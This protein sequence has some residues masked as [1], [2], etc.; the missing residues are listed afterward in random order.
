MT[1]EERKA[2]VKAAME[3]RNAKN[4][5][6]EKDSTTAAIAKAEKDKRGAKKEKKHGTTILHS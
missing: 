1:E 6:K 4:I 3:K 2:A 5:T